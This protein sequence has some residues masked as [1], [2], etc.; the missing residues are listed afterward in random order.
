MTSRITSVIRAFRLLLW[1]FVYDGRCG[2][3]LRVTTKP[4][5]KLKQS[6]RVTRP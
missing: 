3:S 1:P 2:M 6:W 4:L 5:F